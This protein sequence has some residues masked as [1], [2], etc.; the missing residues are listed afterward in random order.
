MA[1]YLYVYSRSREAARGVGATEAGCGRRIRDAG[2]IPMITLSQQDTPF[3]RTTGTALNCADPACRAAKESSHGDT[4]KRLAS[5][6]GQRPFKRLAPA[7]GF[8][9]RGLPALAQSADMVFF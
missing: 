4:G 7:G 2:I 3:P 8:L 1:F 9:L 5:T 6:F